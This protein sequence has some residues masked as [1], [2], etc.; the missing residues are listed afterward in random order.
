MNIAKQT[1]VLT[2]HSGDDVDVNRPI[3]PIRAPWMTG[4]DPSALVRA[5]W[6]GAFSVKR[7]CRSGAGVSVCEFCRQFRNWRP[8]IL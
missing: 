4:D 7:V 3:L 5:H 1:D 6:H 8:E 2:R